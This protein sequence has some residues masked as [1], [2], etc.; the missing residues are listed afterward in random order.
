MTIDPQFL[1]AAPI[2]LVE[3]SKK[4]VEN[5]A[6]FGSSAYDIYQ[7]FDGRSHYAGTIEYSRVTLQ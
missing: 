5:I 7:M 4:V 6:V 3:R 2:G 1:G